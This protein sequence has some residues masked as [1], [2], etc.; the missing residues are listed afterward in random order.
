MKAIIPAAGLGTRFLPATKCVPKEMLPLLNKPTIQYVVEE[1][2]AVSDE[3]VIVT[4]RQ[5][6]QLASYFSRDELLE[7]TLHGM[8]KESCVEK[9]KDVAKLPVSFEYQDAPK[10][11]GHAVHC[12]S[13][14]TG[15]DSFFVLLGDYVVPDKE[16]LPRMLEV[17]ERHGG[18]SVIAVAP[19]PMEEVSRYGI[20][21]GECIENHD[22]TDAP[23]DETAPGAVWKIDTMVEKPAVE[24]APS[25]LFVVG[26]YLLSARVMRLL[27]TQKPG[28]GG[29][30]QLTDAMLRSLED[31]EMYAVV[32]D[33]GEGL[34]TG[35]PDAWVKS[36]YEMMRRAEE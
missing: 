35:T 17:S 9:V 15:D 23:S 26:R 2:L 1:A 16:M 29:E 27:E 6:P 13:T 7:E 21:A 4:S 18:A 11:L 8:G 12:A 25:N 20:I 30:I 31:E 5:K 33:P 14:K 10:G 24:D 3:A 19:C 36:N 28:A 34:D 32:I 22:G